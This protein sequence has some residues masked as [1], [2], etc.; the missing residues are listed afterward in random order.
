MSVAYLEAEDFWGKMPTAFEEKVTGKWRDPKTVLTLTRIHSS[1]MRTARS[2]PYGER[3]L[4]R[5]AGVCPGGLCPGMGVSVRG[6]SLSRE[7]S[8]RETPPWTDRRL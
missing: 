4:S 8:V 5:E 1:R 7:V 2:L 3:S 6:G